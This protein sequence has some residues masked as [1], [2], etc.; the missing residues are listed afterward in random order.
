MEQKKKKAVKI[1][2]QVLKRNINHLFTGAA[3]Y[4]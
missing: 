1:A 4:D 3:C 2:G